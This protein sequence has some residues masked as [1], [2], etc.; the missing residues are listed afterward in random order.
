MIQFG[1]TVFQGIHQRNKLAAPCEYANTDDRHRI[2]VIF[3]DE[4][5][6]KSLTTP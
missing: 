1:V 3:D 6:K 5:A 2:R 4:R